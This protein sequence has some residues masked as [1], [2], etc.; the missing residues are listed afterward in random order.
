MSASS[1]KLAVRELA[2]GDAS[3]WDAF[4]ET[5]PSGTFFHYSGWKEVIEQHLGHR[6]YFLLCEDE[7]GISAVLPLARVRSLL[8]GDVL[9]SLPFLVY[10]GVAGRCDRAMAALV[11]YAASLAKQLRVDHLELRHRDGPTAGWPAKETHVTF[12]KEIYDDSDRNLSAIPRKQRAMV[13]KGIKA[14]LSTDTDNDPRRL[15]RILLECKRNLG[16][17][18][19]SQ[20]FIG[21]IIEVFGDKVEVTIV[22]NGSADVAGVMSFRFRDEILPYY[23]G[24]GQNARSVYANDFMYWDVMCRASEDGVRV[25]DYG[26]SQIGSGAYRFKKHWGF[27]PQPLYYECLSVEKPVSTLTPTSSGYARAVRLW[28]RLPLRLAGVLGPPLA[29]RLY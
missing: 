25:F 22:R 11:D 24:G 16:T 6:C 26:R 7:S 20:S 3:A 2:D 19:F 18:F 9:V 21:K 29:Q 8:F 13:R 12:R 17:P 14:G 23:G 27:E 10:G 15:H 1:P 4:V 5:C 28:K